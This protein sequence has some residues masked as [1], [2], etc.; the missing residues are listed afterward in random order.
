MTGRGLCTETAL[1][2]LALQG[3]LM[4]CLNRRY[5][6]GLACRSAVTAS[7]SCAASGLAGSRMSALPAAP[8]ARPIT[9]S[10]VL[11]SPSTEI[12]T[13]FWGH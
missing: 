11:V 10:F 8:L 3:L 12:C 1:A 7:S 9:V 2:C 6:A 4:Q 5:G 13:K